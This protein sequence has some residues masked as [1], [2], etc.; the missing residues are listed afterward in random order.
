MVAGKLS[1]KDGHYSQRSTKAKAKVVVAGQLSPKDGHYINQRMT[2]S[3]T[4]EMFVNP[5]P[6]HPSLR[7]LV[8]ACLA[9]GLAFEFTGYQY[10]KTETIIASMAIEQTKG[11]MGVKVIKDNIIKIVMFDGDGRVQKE[12]QGTIEDVLEL[13]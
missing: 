9:R 6:M 2:W 13:M 10:L 7:P 5:A 12:S 8:L 1:P 4:E 3:T 11:P